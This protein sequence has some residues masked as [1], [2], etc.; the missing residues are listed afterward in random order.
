[1]DKPR[2]EIGRRYNEA[3]L[4]R[5]LAAMDAFLGQDLLLTTVTAKIMPPNR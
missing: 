4:A 3:W 5:D 2:C 1:M